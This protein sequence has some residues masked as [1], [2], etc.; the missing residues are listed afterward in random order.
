MKRPAIDS[1]PGTS[2]GRP[3]TVAPNTTSRRPVSPAS[4]SA[5]AP[6]TRVLRVKPY[7][8]ARAVSAAVDSSESHRETRPGVTVASEVPG[9]SRVGSSSPSSAVC[10]ARLAGSSSRPARHVR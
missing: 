1:M 7:L 9:T 10:Q 8:R 6:W 5:H 4:V 3:E 2:G